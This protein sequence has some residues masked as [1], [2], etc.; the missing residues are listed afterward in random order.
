M[1][2]HLFGLLSSI[3][4]DTKELYDSVFASSRALQEIE[5]QGNGSCLK[6]L[7]ANSCLL[8]EFHLQESAGI[9]L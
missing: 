9:S 6:T 5:V 2:I 7:L 1:S 3:I 8:L 4:R